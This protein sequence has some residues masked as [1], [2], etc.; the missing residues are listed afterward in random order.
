MALFSRKHYEAIASEC[1]NA[2][3]LRTLI[4]NLA[5]MFARDNRAFD[6]DLFLANCGLKLP[7]TASVPVPVPVPA[8]TSAH[9]YGLENKDEIDR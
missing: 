7:V 2:M 9:S 8:S 5:D 6:R 1:Q 4:I 3:S